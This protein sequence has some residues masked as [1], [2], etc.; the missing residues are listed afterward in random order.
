MLQNHDA[1]YGTRYE[2]EDGGVAPATFPISATTDSLSL[3]GL[4]MHTRDVLPAWPAR[5]S[6]SGL[7]LG[8]W[9]LILL[10]GE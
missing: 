3:E 9:K 6:V 1:G 10:V 4:G 8:P 5:S 7:R 2:V